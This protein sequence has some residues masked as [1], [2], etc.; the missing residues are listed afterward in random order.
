MKAR[1]WRAMIYVQHLLGIGHLVRSFR[2]AR[3]MAQHGFETVLVSGGVPVT[4]LEAGDARL[5]QLS[6][7]KAGEDGF[8]SLVHSDGRPFDDRDRATRRAALLALF[9]DFRPDALIIE[10]FP[11]GRR[12]MRFELLPLLEQAKERGTLVASSIRD[13]LQEQAKPERIDETLALIDRYFDLVLVHGA[14][15]GVLLQETFPAAPQ[16]SSKI[17]YTGLVGAGSAAPSPDIHEVIV[18]VGGGAVGGALIEAAL[19]ARKILRQRGGI[20]LDWR[21]LILTGPNIP[22]S[23]AQSLQQDETGLT[24]MRFV[25]DLPQRFKAARVSISQAGY[26]TVADV[27][28]TS[29]AA[30]LVPF[31]A[32]GETEQ[33]RRASAL[34]DRGRC[35]T[36]T[37]AD[38]NAKRLA[39]AV[40]EALALPRPSGIALDGAN[41][42][43]QIIDEQLSAS[44]L[45]AMEKIRPV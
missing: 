10:A 27:L 45:P 26:N 34:A 19:E 32:G 2:I 17:A 25:S 18:S 28:A 38:L 4:G 14:A 29:C 44:H 24:I 6:P 16:F 7:I 35:V 9:D 22:E 21:W 23:R 43:A 36:L 33:T 15:D 5:V 11:F 12:Q 3:A 42:T 40:E 8:S 37:E 1:S 13:I 41:R 31:A 20:P 30:V 39:D